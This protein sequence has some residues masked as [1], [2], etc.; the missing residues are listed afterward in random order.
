MKPQT[1]RRVLPSRAAKGKTPNKLGFDGSLPSTPPPPTIPRPPSKTKRPLRVKDK[2][3]KVPQKIALENEIVADPLASSSSSSSSSSTPSTSAS[4]QDDSSG[5]VAAISARVASTSSELA[6]EYVAQHHPS[7]A[8]VDFCETGEAS[9]PLA[10][11]V[12]YSFIYTWGQYLVCGSA[13]SKTVTI[14]FVQTLIR[15][16][17]FEDVPVCAYMV[18]RKI[19][20]P[21]SSPVRMSA[22]GHAATAAAAAAAVTAAAAASEAGNAVERIDCPML[23]IGFASGN[24]VV[25]RFDEAMPFYLHSADSHANSV[26]CFTHCG[27]KLVSADV[28]GI[29]KVWNLLDCKLL[30]TKKTSIAGLQTMTTISGNGILCTSHAD[31]FLW[32]WAI[33]AHF[34]YASQEAPHNVWH[35]CSTR[36][37]AVLVGSRGGGSGEPFEVASKNRAFNMNRTVCRRKD[38]LVARRMVENSITSRLAVA[39]GKNILFG[40]VANL[41]LEYYVI[42]DTDARSTHLVCAHAIV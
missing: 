11:D 25:W 6:A 9:I 29:I 30:Q 17:R 13:E 35:M 24:I 27:C 20:A 33:D 1:V 15:V 28:R 31:G 26:L 2:R 32:Y 10:N 42:H 21:A 34:A 23:I 7:C 8:Q 12:A 36:D 37:H 4:T 18:P 19:Q 40:L 16:L 39:D 22:R 14:W 41:G 3:T 38:G 5:N